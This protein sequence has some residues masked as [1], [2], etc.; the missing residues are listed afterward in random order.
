MRVER[1]ISEVRQETD[2]GL[3]SLS[4]TRAGTDRLL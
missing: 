3:T 2:Y 4:H 1:Q